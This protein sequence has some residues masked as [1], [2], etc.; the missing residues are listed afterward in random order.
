MANIDEKTC[1]RLSDDV[2]FQSLGADQDT[3]LLSLTTGYLYT[4]NQTTAALL[5]AID[6]QRN[7]GQIVDEML[8]HFEVSREKLYQ[9]V[10]GMARELAKEALVVCQ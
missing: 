4:C 3:V 5:Q 6:G 1:L 10:L 9:D 8:Q 7:L 2:T